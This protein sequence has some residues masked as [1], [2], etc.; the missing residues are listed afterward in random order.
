MFWTLVL[1]QFFILFI[2]VLATAMVSS[3]GEAA[4]AAVSM[5]GIINGMVSLMFTSL[6]SGGGIVV[7]RAKG[8]ADHEDIR[9]AIGE[10]TGLCCMVAIAFGTLLY[11]FAEPLVRTIYPDVEPMLI[12]YAVQYMHL[13][14]ISFIPYSIFAAIFTYY[15]Y[16][17]S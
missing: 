13:M 1:D 9:H 11:I 2:N 3:I 6:A 12:T 8:R 16:F 14:A 4:I 7:A 10:V 15:W 5:V 17:S